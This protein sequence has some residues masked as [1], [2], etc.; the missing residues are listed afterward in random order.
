[1]IN[2][3]QFL[4]LDGYN[5]EKRISRRKKAN[6]HSNEF[7]TP[8]SIVKRMCEK[9]PE[10]D[11]SDPDKTFLEPC[12]GNFQFGV[13][14][15]WNRI[16]HGISWVTALSTLY[17]IELMQDNIDEGR[18]RIIEML[19]QICPDFEESIANDIMDKNIICH[20]FFTWN[21]EEWREMTEEEIKEANKKAKK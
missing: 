1:M 15:I 8:Y 3:E 4:S 12:A 2:I 19:S 16:Q 13:Y 14:I 7:F 20:D 5:T 21:F 6:I 18:N 9:I 17:M 11:W 10:S